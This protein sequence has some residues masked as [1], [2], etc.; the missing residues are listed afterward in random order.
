MAESRKGMQRGKEERKE[1]G[2][3]E[4]R[5]EVGRKERK[6]RKIS[7]ISEGLTVKIYILDPFAYNSKR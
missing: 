2:R 3:E 5:E 7:P 4:S 6:E 1:Q